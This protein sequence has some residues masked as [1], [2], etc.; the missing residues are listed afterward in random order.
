MLIY[1]QGV[2]KLRILSGN[3]KRPAREPGRILSRVLKIHGKFSRQVSQKPNPSSSG[4]TKK[5]VKIPS[6]TLI[7]KKLLKFN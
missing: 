5:A 1:V 4:D 7:P 6:K 3:C 2:K